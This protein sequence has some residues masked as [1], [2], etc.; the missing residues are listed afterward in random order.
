MGKTTGF[1]ILK[2]HL[3]PTA[4]PFKGDRKCSVLTWL[5]KGEILLSKTHKNNNKNETTD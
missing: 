1:Y 3:I 5:Q 2:T 4:I